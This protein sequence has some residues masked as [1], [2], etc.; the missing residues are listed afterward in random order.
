VGEEG[1]VLVAVRVLVQVAVRVRVAVPVGDKVEA[2][3]ARI[4][5]VGVEVKVRLFDAELDIVG[6]ESPVRVRVQVEL[7]VLTGERAMDP[8]PDRVGEN[9]RVRVLV[10]VEVSEAFNARTPLKRSGRSLICIRLD[11]YAGKMGKMPSS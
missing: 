8:C 3:D 9:D 11:F 1:P 7:K 6:V 4:V 2:M 5:R 10:C